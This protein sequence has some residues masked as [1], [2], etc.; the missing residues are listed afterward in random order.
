MT[1]PSAL[2]LALVPG[3]GDCHPQRCRAQRQPRDKDSNPIVPK[4]N[5][6]V[7]PGCTGRRVGRKTGR[8]G[9]D[10]G[11]G[12]SGDPWKRPELLTRGAATGLLLGGGADTGHHSWARRAPSCDRIPSRDP[13]AL[14]LRTVLAVLRHCCIRSPPCC[15]GT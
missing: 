14:V 10:V 9:C 4:L 12:D 6:E 7:I 8:E 1:S 15:R 2:I 13:G 11:H 3:L 5:W